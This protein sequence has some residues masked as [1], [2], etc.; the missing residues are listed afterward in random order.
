MTLAHRASSVAARECFARDSLPCFV[1]AT[2]GAL[3]IEGQL[4]APP[5]AHQPDA[6]EREDLELVSQSS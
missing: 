6:D 4:Q 5:P 1:E 3:V 2:A